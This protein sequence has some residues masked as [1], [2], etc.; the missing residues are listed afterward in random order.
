[1]TELGMF[2]YPWDVAAAGAEAFVDSLHALGVDRLSLATLYH[3]A[4]II[5]PNRRKKVSVHAEANVAHLPLPDQAFGDIKPPAG[6][7]AMQMPGLFDDIKQAADKRGMKLTGWTIAFHNSDLAQREPEVAIEN[8][9]GD[10]FAHGLCPAHPR[11]ARY[12]QD[13]VGALAGTGHFDRV[14]VESLSYLL[15]GHGHPHELWGARLDVQTRYMLSMCFCPSCLA[16]ADRRGIDGTGLRT[17]VADSLH[18][19]WNDPLSLRR[20]D[21]DGTELAARLV[22][23]DDFRAYARMRCDIVSDLALRLAE[24]AHAHDV[25]LELSAAV[26][27]RPGSLNW[28]EGVDIGA[29]ARIADRFVLES[30]Y[31]DPGEVAREIDHVLDYAPAGKLGLVQT[32]W[33]QHH[34]SLAGLKDKVKI[35]LDA[36]I[37]SIALYNYSMAPAPVVGWISEIARQVKN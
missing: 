36:G 10:R 7:L 11:A 2:T 12:A 25:E 34:G 14:M 9:F 3:S 16:E 21:D 8:C 37:E 28:T 5:A 17:R 26:W 27:G 13:M 1:V 35:A 30:Y 22:L 24:T 18:R 4:E 29:S 23:D 31:P 15:Y 32:V 33:P 19:T 6:Q 20:N